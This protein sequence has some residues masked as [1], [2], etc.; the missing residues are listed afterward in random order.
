[1]VFRSH[2]GKG[3]E[4]DYREGH[5]RKAP[6]QT[7]VQILSIVE[8]KRLVFETNMQG[9]FCCRYFYMVFITKG[10]GLGEDYEG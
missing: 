8:R 6:F 1:M 5:F 9:V 7:A 3:F 4:V 10:V 2:I